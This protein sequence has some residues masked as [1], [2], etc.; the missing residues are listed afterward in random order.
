MEEWRGDR[1]KAVYEIYLRDDS[2]FECWAWDQLEC[3]SA[4]AVGHRI[5]TQTRLGASAGWPRSV[6]VPNDVAHRTA[7]HGKEKAQRTTESKR[8]F[9]AAPF[10]KQTTVMNACSCPESLKRRP[11]DRN[12]GVSDYHCNHSAF[13]GYHSTSS[14]YSQ[15]H[16]LNCRAT[17]RSKGKY[18]EA[19]PLLKFIGGDWVKM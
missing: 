12:W 15:V 11:S 8:D 1:R 14:D 5:S 9:S 19:L 10:P 7:R 2:V 13:N 3:S 16:C 18:V 6:A 4:S 17:W